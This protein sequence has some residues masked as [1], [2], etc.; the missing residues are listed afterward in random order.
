[1]QEK[2]ES[3]LL[4]LKMFWKMLLRMKTPNK[5][6]VFAW[7][8]C[9]DGL[10]TVQNLRLKQIDVED[11]CHSCQ[12]EGED[13]LHALVMC[14][15]IYSWWLLYNP[16]LQLYLKNFSDLAFQTQQV[17][18]LEDLARFFTMAWALWY[19]RN[20]LVHEKVELEQNWNKLVQE[21]A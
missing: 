12:K 5:V 2:G 10:P 21:G 16:K 3:S 13:L 4:Q 14:P 7:R 9:R 8:A 6:K 17:G 15:N 20:K 1:M 19:R 18:N 11:K